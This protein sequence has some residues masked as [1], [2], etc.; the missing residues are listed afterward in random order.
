MSTDFAD[1]CVTQ[2]CPAGRYVRRS[3]RYV[4]RT[5]GDGSQSGTAAASQDVRSSARPQ[6]VESV[7]VCGGCARDVPGS[8]LRPTGTPPPPG[9]I[10][11]GS[12][13]FSVRARGRSPTA[14]R[15]STVVR[16]HRC[17]TTHAMIALRVGPSTS[18]QRATCGRRRVRPVSR[19][20]PT[21]IRVCR[22]LSAKAC[23]ESPRYD[24]PG[25]AR[26]VTS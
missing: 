1:T 4:R 25:M 15:C 3:R 7:T 19:G 23:P 20:S 10:L 5:A 22:K 8:R 21:E 13:S 11:V 9:A 26:M 16:A 14:R 24:R 6:L 18:R 17:R 12:G 2:G